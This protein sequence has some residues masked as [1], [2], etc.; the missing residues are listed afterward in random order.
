MQW[1]AILKLIVF[2]Q[3]ACNT[4]ISFVN[5]ENFKSSSLFQLPRLWGLWWTRKS[6]RRYKPSHGK[7]FFKLKNRPAVG[8]W[9]RL[10]LIRKPN[11]RFRGKSFENFA[12]S[13]LF[14]VTFFMNFVKDFQWLNPVY[15]PNFEP[16]RHIPPRRST[17]LYNDIR[18]S[19]H[20]KI[21]NFL[22]NIFVKLTIW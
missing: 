2:Y 1:K 14:R 10:G 7:I 5:N 20:Y 12:N 6:P 19:K 18:I 8:V 21:G 9:Y 3:N 13:V 22:L 4:K 15:G 16:Q 17:G 11:T